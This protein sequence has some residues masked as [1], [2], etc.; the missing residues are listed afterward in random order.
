M[1]APRSFDVSRGS[2]LNTRRAA[3]IAVYI[4]WPYCARI[5]P[6]CDFNVYKQRRDDSL[7]AAM[8]SDLTAWREMSGP[9]KLT[10]VHFG[11]GTPSLM[12]ADD[13]AELI[14]AAGA[15][16]ELSPDTEIAIEANPGDADK[17]RWSA[18]RQAGINRLSL[19]VQSFDDQVLRALGRDHNGAQGKAALA[20]ALPIFAS[21]SADII[22]GHTGQTLEH[23][24][25]E[26][27]EL[28]GLAPP[29]IS[30][31]QLT[32]EA[33]T[34]FA[35]AQA[36]G[37]RRA[38]G[39]DQSASLYEAA[40]ERLGAAG[41]DGYEVSNYAKPGHLSSHNLA[42]WQGLDYAGVGPGAHGRLT[43]GAVRTAS[44]AAA[45]PQDYVNAVTA[46][47]TGIA[48]NEVLTRGARAAEY[49]MMGLRI[50]DGISCAHYAALSGEDFDADVLTSLIGM[51]LLAREG[52]RLYA[53]AA[54]RLVLNT[55]C[56]KLLGG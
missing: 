29:H 13:I 9:R 54:G 20:L 1:P 35:A 11:G 16:W 41:Y 19:G 38:V 17:A 40:A 31:Y 36:R 8:I 21:V 2:D 50:T 30:A 7:L 14:S 32:I 10:S 28:L 49:V 26:F 47:G 3:E 45:K 33:G 34:A 53:K 48:S 27:D 46:T 42:Y 24:E 15:L 52:D 44:V 43:R 23:L 51:G 6:Y 55:V 37:E 56:A 18:Y 4:H 12:P 25:A 5:C 22:F 39:T